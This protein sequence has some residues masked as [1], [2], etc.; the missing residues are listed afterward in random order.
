M[1]FTPCLLIPIYNHK[2]SIRGVVERLAIWQVPIFIVDDGSNQETQSA[3]DSLAKEMPLV[4]LSRLPQNSGKG[5][6]VM[7]GMRLAQAAGFTHALQIDA[8]GQHNPADV[9][10]FLERGRA[11]PESV[12][13]GSPVYDD[14][15]PKARLYGRYVTHFWVWIETISFAIEDSLCGYRLYPLASTRRL[16]DEIKIPTRMDF[17][18]AIVV[19]LFWRGIA[20]Q[21][22]STRVTYPQDGLS[23]FKLWRD[24]LRITKMHTRLICGMLVRLPLL[25]W[26]KLFPSTKNQTHWSRM[27]E[28]G[29]TLGLRIV[30][31]CYRLIGERAAR[32]LL[33]PIVTYFFLTAPR[34][35]AASLDYLHKVHALSSP[36]QPTPGQRDVFKHMLAFAQSGLDKLAA[37]MGKIDGLRIDVPNRVAFEQLA[38]HRQGALFIGSHLGN[39]EM[40]RALAHKFKNVKINAVVFSDHALRFHDM[41]ARLNPEYNVNL[42]QVSHFSPNTAIQLKEK[43]DRGEMVFIVGDR[44][45]PAENGRICQVDFLGAQAPFAQ[46]PFILASLLECPVYLFF[47]LRENSGYRIYLEHFADRIALPRK[48]RLPRLQAYLQTYAKRLETYCLKAPTQWFNFYDFWQHGEQQ[49]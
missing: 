5:A 30:Y 16:I 39:L 25:L 27:T 41:L 22:I 3:L 34:A 4:R 40:S 1:S 6:A 28:R 36:D 21:N 46:G 13:C 24:N 37:W 8:D 44:T 47:C 12:V 17:D 31:A 14:S 45:P 9:P 20:V 26:R 23:H 11:H 18:T 33:Y 43:I 7:H 38:N 10:H 35:R 49:P 19:R 42:I 48:E 2:D 29:S 32:C 15:I